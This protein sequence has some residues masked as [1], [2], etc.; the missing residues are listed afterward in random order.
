MSLSDRAA[1][2]VAV[3]AIAGALVS[4]PLP[5]VVVAGA[6]AVAVGARRPGLVVVAVALL[7]SALGAR[8]WAGLEPVDRGPF[9]GEVV[10][11][12]DPERVHGAVRVDVR[13]PGTGDWRPGHGAR[14]RAAW[15][16]PS[17]GSG[18]GS[19]AGSGPRRPTR[20]GWCPATSRAGS[21]S[22]RCARVGRATRPAGWPTGC[23]GRSCAARRCSSPTTAA[24]VLG[25][26]LGDDR[27][28]G[29]VVTDDFR[30]SG[31]SHAA[32]GVGPERGVRA[33][34]RGAVPA[35]RG[36]HGGAGSRRWS[37]AFF[38]VVTRL[39]PSVLRATAMS[40]FA[41]GAAAAGRPASGLGS[42]RWR[43]RGWC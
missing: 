17:R 23:D 41:V 36:P 16:T 2:A 28:Q 9:R 31:L 34:A 38:A 15:P 14:R 39:E 21:R 5:F 10:L 18:V 25:M 20:G 33:G 29:P 4:R 37:S 3:A 11:V 30:G 6:V 26:V 1:V 12:G 22:P 19:R 7:A 35:L 40:G 27:G 8:A 42:S 13:L 43:S 32:R 24:P